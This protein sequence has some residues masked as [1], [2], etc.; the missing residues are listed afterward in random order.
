MIQK[1]WPYTRGYRKW[2]VFGVLCSACE[3]V[4]ELLLPLVMADIVDTGIPSGDTGYIL[5]RGALMVLMAMVSMSLGIGSAVFSS[6]AGQGFGAN[7]RQAQYDHIQ[8][9]SFRNIEKF[10]TASLVTRL[11]NDCNMLQMSLMMGMRLLVRAPVMLISALVLAVSIS[12]K[13]SR[14]FLFAMPLLLVLIGLIVKHVSPMFS[15]LQE[16]TDDVNLAVQENLSGIR[17]VKSFVREDHEEE[18]FRQRNDALRSTSERAFGF[19]VM[20]MPVMMLIT[21]GTI[22]AVMWYGAPLVQAGELEVGLLSTFFTYITQV[23]MSLMMVSMIMMMLTRAVACAKRV[24]EV[25]DEVPDIADASASPGLTVADGSV[26]FDHVSFKY[27]DGSEKWNLRDIDLHIK[28]G[29]TVGVIG[30][31]GSAKSTLVQLIPRLYE[32]QEGAVRVGGRPVQ[33]YTMAHLRDAVSMVLQKNTLFSGTIRENLLWGNENASSADIEAAC[34]AACAAEFIHK[35]PDGYDTDL[36]QGGVNVSGGQKQRL[37]IARA[38]LKKPKVLILDDSTSAV[39]TATDA[40]IR[41]AFRTQLPDTTKIIIAQRIVSVMD[42]D[43]IVVMDDGR[44]ADAG[45]HEELMKTSEIYRDVYQSQQEG[46]SIDG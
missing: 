16:R 15:S 42:A 46:A 30:G 45:T 12:S 7:L 36:G 10:S 43:L 22:I 25:L 5:S 41:A 3:A 9:F 33:D 38:I 23:L 28:S 11:T 35:M 18:K 26:D 31:T 37:C 13:L 4:F 44:V 2:I 8:D 14:V 21:Y 34:E 24:A 19:V 29:M 17:V 32:A 27:N 20:N 39:D 6:R 40:K 1:L